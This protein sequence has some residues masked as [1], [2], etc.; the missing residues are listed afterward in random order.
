MDLLYPVRIASLVAYVL[1]TYM[2]FKASVLSYQDRGRNPI[3]YVLLTLT[4]YASDPLRILF[5]TVPHRDVVSN[6]LTLLSLY[7]SIKALT[8]QRLRILIAYL[9][10]FSLLI[11]TRPELALFYSVPT[12]LLSIIIYSFHGGI[13]LEFMSR[14]VLAKPRRLF[15]YVIGGRRFLL[16][17]SVMLFT[18]L[19]YEFIHWFFQ[20]YRP[21]TVENSCLSSHE[22]Y[23]TYFNSRPHKPLRM[24]LIRF[25]DGLG[26]YM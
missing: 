1:S 17:I 25:F 5:S 20:Q 10:S 24:A 12:I 6:L 19:F 15:L 11:V 4:I 2:F 16:A 9:G 8:S 22:L 18:L 13:L 26:Q 14:L 7:L 3:T 21:L 23:I